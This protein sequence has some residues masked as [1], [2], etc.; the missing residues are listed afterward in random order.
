MGSTASYTGYSSSYEPTYTYNSGYS[1]NYGSG[2]SKGYDYPVTATAAAMTPRIW[3]PAA[4]FNGGE[5]TDPYWG[6]YG[7]T[8]YTGG[9]SWASSGSGSYSDN[10]RGQTAAS[11]FVI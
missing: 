1:S 6:Y 8:S 7:N 4:C 11:S 10:Y 2:Y 5:V 9:S 3:F